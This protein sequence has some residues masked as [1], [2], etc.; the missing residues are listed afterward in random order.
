M[1]S[2]S[3]PLLSSNHHSHLII[4]HSLTLTPSLEPVFSLILPTIVS[5]PPSGLT[6]QTLTGTNSSEL[7]QFFVFNAS[8]LPFPL[9]V[10]C[11]RLSGVNGV[12][13]VFWVH[14]NIM[15]RIKSV[16][17]DLYFLCFDCPVNFWIW[18]EMSCIFLSWRGNL[19]G[20]VCFLSSV[21]WQ[22][23]V[24]CHSPGDIYGAMSK[25]KA[26]G[27]TLGVGIDE[28]APG[29]PDEMMRPFYSSLDWVLSLWVHFTVHR[30]FC[31]SVCILHM[32]FYRITSISCSCRSVYAL[33]IEFVS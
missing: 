30:F 28:H 16:K 18:G 14:I 8:L 33:H 12:F 1:I 32:F 9:L 24:C 4:Y 5:L 29:M 31:L 7:F 21:Q 26:K 22:W 17:C 10:L 3:H 19:R 25:F 15:Y 23:I 27:H 11:A 2:L 6:P 13:W 20:G